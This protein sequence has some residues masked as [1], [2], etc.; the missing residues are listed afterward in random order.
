MSTN[1]SHVLLHFEI[2]PG[3][4]GAHGDDHSLGAGGPGVGGESAGGFLSSC[5]EKMANLICV[6]QPN[7][8]MAPLVTRLMFDRNGVLPCLRR[9]LSAVLGMCVRAL[10]VCSSSCRWCTEVR[11]GL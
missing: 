9:D 1:Y 3:S 11:A 7:C 6:K 5:G 4:A 8:C 2:G 10:N